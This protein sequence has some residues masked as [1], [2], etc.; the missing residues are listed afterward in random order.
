[1]N[2]FVHCRD[3]FRTKAYHL[4]NSLGNLLGRTRFFG[5]TREL[6]FLETCEPFLKELNGISRSPF[7]FCLRTL[8]GQSKKQAWGGTLSDRVLN[9]NNL[10]LIVVLVVIILVYEN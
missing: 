8:S 5:G 6:G 2:L 9:F 3:M 10:V 7:N 1:M 4:Y